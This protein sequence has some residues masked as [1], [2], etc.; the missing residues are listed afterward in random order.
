M[1]PNHFCFYVLNFG[2]TGAFRLLTLIRLIIFKCTHVYHIFH[3]RL[4]SGSLTLLQ[5]HINFPYTSITTIYERFQPRHS[6]PP[7]PSP[8]NSLGDFSSQ[9]D[10]PSNTLTLGSWLP[11]ILQSSSL[12][13]HQPSIPLVWPRT[14]SYP[15][16][17]K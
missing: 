3:Y 16:I 9:A 14:L 12:H 7:H 2:I 4:C 10:G 1:L 8:A 11:D 6:L 15:E 5:S 17:T 13:P